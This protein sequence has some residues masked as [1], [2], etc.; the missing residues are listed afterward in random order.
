LIK[1]LCSSNSSEFLGLYSHILLHFFGSKKLLEK[2]SGQS[3]ISSCHPAFIYECVLCTHIQ[4]H[5]RRDLGH[6]DS[7][8]L[9]GVSSRPLGS[10]QVPRV[11]CVCVC[12]YIHTYAHVF[13]HPR[14]KIEKTQT[15]P[16][17]LLVSKKINPHAKRQVLSID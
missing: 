10:H 1:G 4:I 13:C 2:K 11:Q 17:F 9:P 14:Q 3:K 7:L 12:A 6:L 16:V 15:T 8:G 5:V